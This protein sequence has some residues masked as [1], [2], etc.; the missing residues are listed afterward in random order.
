MTRNAISVPTHAVKHARDQQHLFTARNLAAQA[1]K[2]IHG[3]CI[4]ALM[5]SVGMQA[6]I[7]FGGILLL[8]LLAWWCPVWGARLWYKGPRHSYEI[9]LQQQQQQ[10]LFQQQQQA[11]S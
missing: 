11:A 7:E 5:S 1:P 4:W 2:H 3:R 6:P 8:L 9:R 10:D